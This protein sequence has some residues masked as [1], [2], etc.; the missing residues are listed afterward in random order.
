MFVV[1]QN[2]RRLIR[3]L[4]LVGQPFG[5]DD[6]LRT[7]QED[8]RLGDKIFPLAHITRLG[9]ALW[10]AEVCEEM[11]VAALNDKLRDAILRATGVSV[12]VMS[13]ANI[14]ESIKFAPMPAPFAPIGCDVLLSINGTHLATM[15]RDLDMPAASM[16]DH[17]MI[18]GG[19]WEGDRLS[20]VAPRELAEEMIVVRVDALDADRGYAVSCLDFRLAGRELTGYPREIREQRLRASMEKWH[21]L[22]GEAQITHVPIDL[23]PSPL[24]CAD[25][26][27][28]LIVNG[29]ETETVQAM[30]GWQSWR[31]IKDGHF[32]EGQQNVF[33]I[34][35]AYDIQIE[36][37]VPEVTPL[38]RV[39]VPAQV[40]DILIL[41]GEVFGRA[42]GARRPVDFRAD[43]KYLPSLHRVLR[44]LCPDAGF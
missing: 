10:R 14:N 36:G 1:S 3:S 17:L 29:H 13:P 40:G 33:G 16:P 21:G 26:S 23:H 38:D 6:V 41:D 20:G 18:P 4:S 12:P 19:F 28:Q 7:A 25:A 31:G 27:L 2:D 34:T 30:L 43:D 37:H 42:G 11:P 9:N 39:A 5:P 32:F 8:L 22:S 35:N 15:R 24:Q 44:D